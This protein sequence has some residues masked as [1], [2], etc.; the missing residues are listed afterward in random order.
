MIILCKYSKNPHIP[1]KSKML[2]GNMLWG[3]YRLLIII[4]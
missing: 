2:I 3:C 1:Q 4:W